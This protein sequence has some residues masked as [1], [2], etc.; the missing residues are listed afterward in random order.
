MPVAPAPVLPLAPVGP[1]TLTPAQQPLL[2]GGVNETMHQQ[3]LNLPLGTHCAVRY[4]LEVWRECLTCVAHLALATRCACRNTISFRRH[5]EHNTAWQVINVPPREGL[6]LKAAE[7]QVTHGRCPVQAAPDIHMQPRYASLIN[8]GWYAMPHG[9]SPRQYQQTCAGMSKCAPVLPVAPKP[10]FP[11]GPAWSG[12]SSSA[13]PYVLASQELA[14]T[15]DEQ[16][17]GSPDPAPAGPVLPSMPL[18]PL[19]PSGCC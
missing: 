3:S 7:C 10:V 17:N 12:L 18:V 19:Y 14:C 13:R 15:L 8:T 6:L 11:V 1:V 4:Q 5:L 16:A 9:F 2:V